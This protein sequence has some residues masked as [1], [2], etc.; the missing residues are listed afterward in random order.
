MQVLISSHQLGARWNV[1]RSLSQTQL[2]RQCH[3]LVL[4]KELELDV[5][6]LDVDNHH[7]L[8]QIVKSEKVVVMAKAARTRLERFHATLKTARIPRVAKF[9]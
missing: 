9:V 1:M 7:S 6:G 5:V 8:G 2:L 3:L 4:V